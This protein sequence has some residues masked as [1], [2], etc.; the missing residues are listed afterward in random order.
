MA[1]KTFSTGEVLTASDTNT[2]LANAGLVYITS[3]TIGSA[4][5]TVTVNNVFSSTYNQYLI[6][7]A[8]GTASTSNLIGLQI[9]AATTGYYET[10][11]G[12]SITT[13]AF[14]GNVTN[15]GTTFYVGQYTTTGKS[16][17]TLVINPNLATETRHFSQ[18]YNTDT[19]ACSLSMGVLA[20]T[21]SYTGF[22]LTA[23]AGTWTGGVVTVYGYRIA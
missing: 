21:T 14:I 13:G 7:F 12:T 3:T 8:G 22:T 15:N 18:G 6:T 11:P 9:G 23:L 20:N 5:S 10:R 19:A 1:I 2:F 4:V 16:M 17:H